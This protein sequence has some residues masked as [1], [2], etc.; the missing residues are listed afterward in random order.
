M[1]LVAVGGLVAVLVPGIG[2]SVN[3][4]TRWIDCRLFMIQPSEV[5]KLA[6]ILYLAALLS[7]KK[8]EIRDWQTG[9]LPALI[10][11]VI[12]GVLIM[13]EPDMGTTIMLM[14]TAMT[15]IYMAG[16]RRGH[17]LALILVGLILGSGLILTSHYRRDRILAFIDPFHD[18]QGDGYQ[19][20]QSLT[21]LGSGGIFGLG[22]CESREKLFYLPAKHT[23]FI[24]S[25]LGEETG[26]IGTWILAGLF[27]LFAVRG[28]LI[29]HRTKESFG[30]LL[31]GGISVMIA[32][33]ATGVPL[34]FISYGG[35]S[36]ALNLLSVG[37]LL[38]ISQYPGHIRNYEDEDSNYRR[39]HGGARV[40]SR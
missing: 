18:P 35:S 15:I 8:N 24:F 19:V 31:A 25:V 13:K 17:L 22:I 23:D 34:P 7:T 30:R 4:A 36:L 27:L 11:L 2:V 10:P 26:L 39:R 38:G 16:A 6:I 1:L 37:V 40:S 9:L 20:C 21:A 28:F 14:A 29:A 3:G 32:G 12:M 33:Q 5:A